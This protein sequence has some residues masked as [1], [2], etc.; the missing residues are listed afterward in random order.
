VRGRE[1]DAGGGEEAQR[2]RGGLHA[3][4]VGTAER[5]RGERDVVSVEVEVKSLQ[6]GE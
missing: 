4:G 1:V 6:E 2:S 3:V 5:G